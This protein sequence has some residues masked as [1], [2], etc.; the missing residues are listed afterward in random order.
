MLMARTE[1]NLGIVHAFGVVVIVHAFDMVEQRTGVCVCVA[2]VKGRN[3]WLYVCIH[4][5]TY[6]CYIT[7]EYMV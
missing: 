7:L 6:H 5:Y 2:D 1:T 4:I 3:V